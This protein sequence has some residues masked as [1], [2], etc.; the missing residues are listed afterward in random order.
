V[1]IFAYHCTILNANSMMLRTVLDHRIAI[2]VFV[3]VTTYEKNRYMLDAKAFNA[4]S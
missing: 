1:S 2:R 3:P 4:S